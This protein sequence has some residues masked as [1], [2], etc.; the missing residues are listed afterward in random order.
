MVLC[1]NPDMLYPMDNVYNEITYAFWKVKC[2]EDTVCKWRTSIA[3]QSMDLTDLHYLLPL[4]HGTGT[5]KKQWLCFLACACSAE[6]VPQ[7]SS[8]FLVPRHL[9]W[10][11]PTTPSSSCELCMNLNLSPSSHLLNQICS[12]SPCLTKAGCLHDWLKQIHH[13]NFLV[14]LRYCFAHWSQSSYEGS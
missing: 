13:S 10:R 9:V 6:G 11:S 2:E 12:S 4:H 5:I 1:K 14:V 7:V 3:V 8:T